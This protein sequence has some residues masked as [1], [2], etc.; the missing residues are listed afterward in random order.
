MGTHGLAGKQRAPENATHP[1]TQVT[2]IDRSENL[3]FGFVA[4]SGALRSLLDSAWI[5]LSYETADVLGSGNPE[6]FKIGQNRFKVGPG[7][8]GQ[9]G[10]KYRKTY[11][12]P[13]LPATPGPTFDLFLTNFNWNH[14]QINSSNLFC[15]NFQVQNYRINSCVQFCWIFKPCFIQNRSLQ[16]KLR[17]AKITELFPAWFFCCNLRWWHYRIHSLSCVFRY[18]PKGVL[19]QRCSA[20]F[21]R[22]PDAFSTHF[23]RISD[24]FWLLPTPFP[25]TPFGRYRALRPAL[26]LVT[27][28][29]A[30]LRF[31]KNLGH[32]G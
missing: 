28:V 32:S 18:R 21:W 13:I 29:T 10:Q 1:K 25:K 6:I 3:R 5:R 14:C 17:N 23:W 8:Y 12:W 4:F 26:I 15:C 31:R 16:K 11:F 24:A 22:I 9:I 19:P 20:H 27:T 2:V 30:F 7:V